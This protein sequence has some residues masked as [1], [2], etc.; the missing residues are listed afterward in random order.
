MTDH[1]EG[2]LLS[3]KLKEFLTRQ[4]EESMHNIKK[5]KR[6]RAIIKTL[7]YTTTISSIVIAAAL[8]T[9]A[10]TVIIPPVAI[11]VL[12]MSSAILTGIGAK[13]NFKGTSNKLD[14]EIEKHTKLKNKLDYV[15][16]CNGDLTE[17]I[18]K[19]ILL[20]F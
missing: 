20:E 15:V 6:K 4:L 10:T 14:K 18:Y 7:I 9:A 13:F 5:K 3:D 2:A 19:Q 12:S 8:G 17:E 11:I 16:S 1:A